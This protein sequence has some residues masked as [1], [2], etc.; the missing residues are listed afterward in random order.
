MW[1]KYSPRGNFDQIAKSGYLLHGR[2]LRNSHNPG[3]QN[4]KKR[5]RRARKI[6]SVGEEKGESAVAGVCGCLTPPYVTGN[7]PADEA[8]S[9]CAHVQEALSE[10]DIG[11]GQF[12]NKVQIDI[13]TV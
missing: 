11:P 7:D 3:G 6:R 9:F 2:V 12:H 5:A 10:I 13:D 8:M 4:A 1:S